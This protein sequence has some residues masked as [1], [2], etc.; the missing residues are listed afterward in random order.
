VPGIKE[1]MAVMAIFIF[2]LPLL[3]A[4]CVLGGLDTLIFS[5]RPN[6]KKKRFSYEENADNKN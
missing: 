6:S 4:M 3:L 5:F 1:S 2:A